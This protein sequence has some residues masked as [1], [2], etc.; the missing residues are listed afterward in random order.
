MQP[1]VPGLFWGDFLYIITGK[2]MIDIK[3]QIDS[4]VDAAWEEID[5]IIT[6]MKNIANMIVAW[7][8]S[9]HE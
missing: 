3:H 5:E 2:K 9:P 1:S 8:G 6:T 7:G 4:A